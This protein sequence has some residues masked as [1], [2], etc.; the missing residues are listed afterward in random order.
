MP[1]PMRVLVIGANG[2]TGFQVVA[3]LDGDRPVAE[4][5]ASA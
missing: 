5:L 4:A 3:V 2:R 1:S